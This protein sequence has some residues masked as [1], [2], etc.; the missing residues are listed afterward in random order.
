MKFLTP[1]DMDR[2][3]QLNTEELLKTNEGNN[4]IIPQIRIQTNNETQTK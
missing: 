3:K 1:T 4:H 2:I